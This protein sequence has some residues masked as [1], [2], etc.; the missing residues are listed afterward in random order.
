V[1]SPAQLPR[2]GFYFLLDQK[3]TKNQ[4]SRKA[5][6]RSMPLPCKSGKTAGCNTFAPFHKSPLQQKF[7]NALSDTQP[8]IVLPDFIRSCSADEEK[9]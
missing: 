8:T 7:A 9:E 5:S 3:V 6:L 2:E 4:F 1:Y